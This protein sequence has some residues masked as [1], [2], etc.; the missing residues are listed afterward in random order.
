M[1]LAAGV[2]FPRVLRLLLRLNLR[3]NG[4]VFT[5]LSGLPELAKR[6]AQQI[7][8]LGELGIESDGAAQRDHRVF[9][10]PQ[11]TR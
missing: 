5:G 11:H 3:R 8:S 6:V 10:L 2:E 7:M 9:R 1:L 4:A